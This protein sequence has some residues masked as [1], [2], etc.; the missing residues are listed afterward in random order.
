M[1]TL[2]T[3]F[4]KLNQGWDAQPGVP[5][6]EIHLD[7]S[8][9]TLTFFL[10]SIPQETRREFDRGEL[11]FPNC[12]RYRLGPPDDEGWWKGQCRFR[13]RAQDHGHFYE[14]TGDLR[15]DEVQDWVLLKSRP[16]DEGNHYLFYFKDETF[17]C[18]C[19]RLELSD[20]VHRGRRICAVARSST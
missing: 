5:L 9:L 10:N 2:Q 15:N 18:A 16:L 17:K 7:E 8:G 1:G 14:V 13:C 11:H 20:T 4:S 6:P 19:A 3:D 12:W